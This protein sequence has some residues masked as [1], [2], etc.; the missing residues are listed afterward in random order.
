MTRKK[1]RLPSLEIRTSRLHFNTMEKK[2][3]FAPVFNENS[4]VLI[5]GSFPSVKSRQIDFY[6]GNKQNK[7]W[8]T[9]CGFFGEEIPESN[10]GKIEFLFRR[11]IA[12]WDMVIACE[13]EGSA[14]SSVK[15]A[16]IAD[17]SR[18]LNKAKIE[19]IL[20]NGTLSYDL[21]LSKYENI[22]IPYRKMPSTSPANP[23]FSKQVWED[24]LNDVFRIY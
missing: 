13:I 10:E 23:R 21:F 6:Y 20:L 5:L 19:K 22:S 14:D 17:L 16:E 4:R 2:I 24:E 1:K 18:V 3:G 9:V 11:N 12:L 15:N 7:F 8:K